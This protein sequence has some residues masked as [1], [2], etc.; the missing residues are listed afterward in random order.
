MRLWRVSN[1]ADLSGVGGTL[2]SG[3]W[4]SRGRPVLYAAEHPAGAILEMLAHMDRGEIPATYQL[5]G[6]DAPD[7]SPSEA[8]ALPEDWR[9]QPRITRAIGDRW[10]ADGANLLLR[11]PSALAPHSSNYLINP[12]HAD[13]VNLR[14]ALV[15]PLDLDQRLV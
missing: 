13:V 1:Y 14:L 8:P 11:I 7:V 15:E 9:T 10:L 2:A 4:H 5:L 12:R 3:R 6:I